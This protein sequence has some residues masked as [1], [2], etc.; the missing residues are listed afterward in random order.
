[1]ARHKKKLNYFKTQTHKFEQKM[2]ISKKEDPAPGLLQ[3]EINIFVL[4]DLSPRGDAGSG[5]ILPHLGLQYI[6]A[7]IFNVGFFFFK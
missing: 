3:R 2:D 5:I 7:F 1:M 6:A 4:S